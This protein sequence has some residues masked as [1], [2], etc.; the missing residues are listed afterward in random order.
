M[1]LDEKKAECKAC[2]STITKGCLVCDLETL[3]KC[4][5]C[6]PGYS[7]NKSGECTVEVTTK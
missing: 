2:S 6:A 1:F 5:L 3:G 7:M 4:L